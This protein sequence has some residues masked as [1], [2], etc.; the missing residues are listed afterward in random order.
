[1]D[2][3]FH[4]RTTAPSIACIRRHD[5]RAASGTTG[6]GMHN[7]HHHQRH[8][9]KQQPAQASRRDGGG[10]TRLADM[11]GFDEECYRSA[12]RDASYY[13][14]GRSWRDYA[15]AYR[16]GHAARAAHPGQRF[17][18]VEAELAANWSTLKS[19]SRLLWVEARGAVHDAWQH[20]GA[21]FRGGQRRRR[22]D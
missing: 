13:S 21:D 5:E 6:Y 3:K 17:E 20:S 19:D 7:D 8:G 4:E 14:T 15:P 2:A 11:D 9:G 22:D 16:Y 10:P 18:D 12:Y 1:M